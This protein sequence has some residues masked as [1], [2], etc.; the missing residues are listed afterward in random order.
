MKTSS[1]TNAQ[2]P[3]SFGD[4]IL[5][6]FGNKLMLGIVIGLGLALMATG[7]SAFVA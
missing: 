2:I 6:A 1:K 5:Q 4:S 7:F 3:L